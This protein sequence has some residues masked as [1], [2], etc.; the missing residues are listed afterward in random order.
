MKTQSGNPVRPVL[1]SQ[2]YIARAGGLYK[3]R[4]SSCRLYTPEVSSSGELCLPGRARNPGDKPLGE[5]KPHHHT[6]Q[7]AR[8]PEEMNLLITWG[9]H[10]LSVPWPAAPALTSS[11]LHMCFDPCSHALEA[12]CTPMGCISGGLTQPKFVL[13]LQQEPVH[14]AEVNTV[15]VTWN[16]QQLR[17]QEQLC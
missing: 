17:L 5:C 11:G 6:R 9:Q 16:M 15:T 12:I 7:C 14:K 8:A 13:G 4:A 10:V 2:Q 1:S 3:C